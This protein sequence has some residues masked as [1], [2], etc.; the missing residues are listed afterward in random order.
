[1]ANRI[2]VKRRRFQRRKRSVRK[3][4]FGTKERPRLSVY[5][6]CQLI[7]AQFI[8]D[9][10][11]RTICASSTVAKDVK[12]KLSYGGNKDAA[13]LV[14]EDLAAKALAI[15]IDKVVFDRNGFKYQ[16]RLQALADAAREKGLKF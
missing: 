9:S 16:G 4:I 5:R 1:M 2:L 8:D 11:G 6:S 12:G 3:D 13:K 14:G 15:G 7:Y 10:E